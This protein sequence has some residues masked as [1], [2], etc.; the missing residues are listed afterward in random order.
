[1]DSMLQTE[2]LSNSRNLLYVPTS[3]DMLCLDPRRFDAKEEKVV[4]VIFDSNTKLCVCDAIEALG[5]KFT[6]IARRS[7]Q[8]IILESI[9]FIPNDQ[10]LA[11][12]Q[13]YVEQYVDSCEMLAQ[14]IEKEVKNKRSLKPTDD[15]NEYLQSNKL[16][17]VDIDKY[18]LFNLLCR[19][20]Y[21]FDGSNN[22]WIFIEDMVRNFQTI[23]LFEFFIKVYIL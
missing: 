14:V 22:Y 19:I 18:Q 13:E 23:E 20:Y 17:G 3:I 11:L 7:D 4:D 10:E 6:R 15:F 8:D 9:Q 2:L 1:M 16:D 12:D 21:E 5:L